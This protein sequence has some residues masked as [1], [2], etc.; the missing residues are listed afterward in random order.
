MVS[1]LSI[2][3]FLCWQLLCG[4]LGAQ[5]SLTIE[6]VDPNPELLSESGEFI[7]GAT[8]EIVDRLAGNLP[9]RSGVIA[10]GVSLILLRV[11]TTNAVTYSLSPALGD[12][13]TLDAMPVSARKLTVTPTSASDGTSWTFIIYVP[14]NDLPGAALNKS[15]TIS[16]REPGRSGKVSLGVTAPPVLLVHGVWSSSAT[17]DDLRQFLIG[18]G[19]EFCDSADCV[20]NYGP[21]QP[22]P[23]F[24]PLAVGPENEFAV[25]QLIR[26]TTNTLNALR[27][28][29]IAAAQVDVVAHSLGGLI[30]RSRVVQPGAERAYRRRDNFGRGDFHKLITIG[31]PHRGTSIANFLIANRDATSSFFD[32]ATLEDYLATTGHPIGPAIEQMQ[33]NSAALEHLGATPGVPSH[34]VIGIAPAHSHTED[35]LNT[36]PAALGYFI[37]FDSLLGGNG[38]HDVLVPRS[39]QAGGLPRSATTLVR[40]VVHADLDGRDTGETE[41]KALGRRIAQL[42]V[43][44]SDSRRFGNFT[45]GPTNAAA[46]LAESFRNGVIADPEH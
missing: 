42:L 33:T 10:D 43:T 38:A 3:C 23:S 31:T 11:A 37:S 17:W 29:G 19:F 18:R 28:E 12:L 22:A 21:I 15:V 35:L 9:A 44:R 13:R 30:A 40:G 46:R 2:A 4:S 26:A 20:V 1:R 8:P 14:P 7:G 32:G 16:A 41:S 24:D 36:L 25:D 34:A 5:S 27:E 6:V 45:A 39:S